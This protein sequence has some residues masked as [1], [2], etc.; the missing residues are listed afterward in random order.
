MSDSQKQRPLPPIVIT[1][2]EACAEMLEL[3]AKHVRGFAINYPPAIYP[4]PH[5]G[6][7]GWRIGGVDYDLAVHLPGVVPDPDDRELTPTTAPGKGQK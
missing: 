1:G 7:F 3:L 6:D 4:A 2:R 5:V